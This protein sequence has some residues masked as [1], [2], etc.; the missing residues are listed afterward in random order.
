MN[1]SYFLVQSAVPGIVKLAVALAVAHIGGEMNL[2]YS[3]LL[4]SLLPPLTA[5]AYRQIV[6]IW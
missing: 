6:A 3:H 4:S 1:Y 5:R 2:L